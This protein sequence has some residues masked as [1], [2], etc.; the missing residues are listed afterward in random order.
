MVSELKPTPGTLSAL[1]ANEKV[2][3]YSTFE[4]ARDVLNHM[5]HLKMS[6]NSHKGDIVD[7]A[8]NKEALEDAMSD[9]LHELF[10]AIQN[11]ADLMHIIEE[12]ADVQNYLL[13]AVQRAIIDYRT[14]K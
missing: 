5:A 2:L 8:K 13:A 14:R 1:Q 9:E 11:E 3:K 7:F 4:E 10:A 6:M 12:A